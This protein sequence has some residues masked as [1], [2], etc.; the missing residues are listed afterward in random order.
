MGWG[1]GVAEGPQGLVHKDRSFRLSGFLQR[2]RKQVA[3]EGSLQ[4][5]IWNCSAPH[6]P[7][8][9]CQPLATTSF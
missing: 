2:A 9:T 6:S 7:P 5:D 1:S 8:R 3:R 4:A